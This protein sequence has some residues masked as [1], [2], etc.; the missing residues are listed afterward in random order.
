M[1]QMHGQQG[2]MIQLLR[3][4]TSCFEPPYSGFRD[5]DSIPGQSKIMNIPVFYHKVNIVLWALYLAMFR[6]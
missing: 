5:Q 1:T 6:G 4:E 2:Q 3:R